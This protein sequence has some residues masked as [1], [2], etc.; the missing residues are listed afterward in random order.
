MLYWLYCEVTMWEINEKFEKLH[1]NKR[2][3]T[4]IFEAVDLVQFN[5]VGQVNYVCGYTSNLLNCIL[6]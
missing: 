6:F 3:N 1:Y 4:Q 2:I 5:A